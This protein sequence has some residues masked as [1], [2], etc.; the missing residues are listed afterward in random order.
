MK[1]LY[2]SIG[3]IFVTI[4]FLGLMLGDFAFNWGT[5]ITLAFAG[6]NA[7]GL[8]ILAIAHWGMK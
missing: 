4:G 8:I 6:I 5:G 2:K 3:F 1:E 7:C